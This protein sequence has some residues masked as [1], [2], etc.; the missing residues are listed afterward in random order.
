MSNNVTAAKPKFGG[1][2]Y[3]APTG[4]TLPTDATTALNEAFTTLG[5]ISDAGLVNSTEIN[6]E[7][8]KAW[9]GDEVLELFQ[10][11]TDSFNF[12]LIEAL[13]VNVLKLVYGADNVTGTL[14]SGITINVKSNIELPEQVMVVEMNMKGN[15]VK[16]IVIPCATVTNVGDITYS[17][18]DVVGYDTTV[19]AAPDTAGNTHYEY[20]SGT[21]GATGATNG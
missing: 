15:T 7:T 18:S 5:Y 8:K 13:D 9:G 2:V 20:I 3:V 17:D 6:T 21:T 4:T 14:V 10:G 16:R 11:R 12:T 1:A 19:K